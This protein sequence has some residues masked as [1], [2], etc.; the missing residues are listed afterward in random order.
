[1]ACQKVC[2]QGRDENEGQHTGKAPSL[3]LFHMYTHYT[4]LAP[5]PWLWF[6]NEH[7]HKLNTTILLGTEIQQH[8]PVAREDLV[9]PN[10]QYWQTGYFAIDSLR[11]DKP[12]Y[13]LYIHV[14]ASV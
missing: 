7:M 1:M 12:N 2:K 10:F 4:I 13:Y 11:H 8:L 9:W 14:K 3:H 5:R 6:G